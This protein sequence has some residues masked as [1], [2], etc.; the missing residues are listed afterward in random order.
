MRTV[1][2]MSK[3]RQASTPRVAV[4]M[5]IHGYIHGYI[6]VWILG[7]CYTVDISMD[8]VQ[9]TP[10]KCMPAKEVF[11][12]LLGQLLPASRKNVVQKAIKLFV[13]YATAAIRYVQTLSRRATDSVTSGV[14]CRVTVISLSG[15]D[16]SSS[17]QFAC[18]PADSTSA[19]MSAA[20]CMLLST[21]KRRWRGP[22]LLINA[23]RLLVMNE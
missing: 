3:S 11:Q 4:D 2:E 10:L 20:V 1:V 12:R 16:S 14:D 22:G 18:R 23:L 9:C 13:R 21:F 6:H 8:I 19:L 15:L 17:G 5:D 7:L